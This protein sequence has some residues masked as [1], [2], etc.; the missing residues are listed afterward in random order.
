MTHLE[1]IYAKSTPPDL[2]KPATFN[3]P[4]EIENRIKAEIPNLSAG[5]GFVLYVDHTVDPSIVAKAVN[6]VTKGYSLTW[7][8]FPPAGDLCQT[9]RFWRK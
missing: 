6:A 7:R 1:F 3:L 5:A 8:A 4:P 2:E 9:V